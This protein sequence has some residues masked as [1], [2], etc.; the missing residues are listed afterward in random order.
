MSVLLLSEV[1]PP[2][3]GGSGRWFWEI[4]RRL[5]REEY[6]V[7]AGSPP[8]FD[9]FDRTHDLRVTRLSLRLREWGIRSAVG[10]RDYTRLARQLRT[11]IRVPP[12]GAA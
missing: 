7:A 2:Q 11:R 3:T 12:L 8:G 9:S 6:Q 1:F 4:Y 5:P 10:L